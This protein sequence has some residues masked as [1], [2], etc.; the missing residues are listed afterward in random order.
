VNFTFAREGDSFKQ[1]LDNLQRQQLDKVA[2]DVVKDAADEA[3]K[4]GRANIAASGLR[5]RFATGL[6]KRFYPNNN[7]G[8]PAALIY[9]TKWYSIVFERG[10]HITGGE[11]LLWLPV[12][13]NLPRAIRSPS[14]YDGPLVSVNVA[15]KAPM[16]FDPRRRAD[17]PLFVGVR[18]A[19][20]RKRLDLYRIFAAAAARIPEFLD[21][22]LKGIE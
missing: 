14:E 3:L 1:L 2:K 12:E 5:G 8:N 20:I 21:K 10:A 16:L 11:H 22:R 7:T 19:T 13:Q 9:H 17:G 18:T 4:K 15:G 6:K